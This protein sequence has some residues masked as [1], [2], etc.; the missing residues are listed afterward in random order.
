M[1]SCNNFMP[2]GEG[3]KYQMTTKNGETVNLQAVTKI[4]P[5]TG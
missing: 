4:D 2:K 5:A 1:H 3:E